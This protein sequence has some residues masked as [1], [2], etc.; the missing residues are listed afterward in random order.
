MGLRTREVLVSVWATLRLRHGR[1]RAHALFVDAL[2][3]L[4]ANPSSILPDL[5]FPPPAN[6]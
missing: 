4:A 2:D 5:L 6:P 1:D 3:S